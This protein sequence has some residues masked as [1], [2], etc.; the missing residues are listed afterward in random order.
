MIDIPFTANLFMN[1]ENLLQIYASGFRKNWELP[2]LTEFGSDQTMTYADLARRIAALHLLYE[3]AGIKRGDKIAVMGKNSFAW[4]VVYMATLTYGAVIVPVLHDFNVQDAQHIINHSESVMLFINESIFDSMEFEKIPAVKAVL[5][6]D[7]RAVLAEHPVTNRVVE[8]FLA[9]LPQ[10][11]R[12]RYPHGFTTADVDYPEIDES[13]LAEINYTSGTTGFSKGVMLTLGNLGGNVRFGMASRLHYRGSRALSFLPLAHAYGCAFDMLTPLAV[14]T[15]ITILGKLPTP[16]LLLK[17]FAEVRPNLIIC[18][19]LILEKIYRNKLRPIIEKP[20][21]R[22]ALKLPGL[23]TLVYRKI[24]NSLVEA[25][26]GEFE[27]VIVGGAPLNHE[28]EA[29]LHKIKFPFTVGYGMTECGPLISYTP[30]RNFIVSS[31]GRTLPTMES[32]IAG[33]RNPE[34]EPG[35]ICVR[36]ENVM[37][38]YFK[39]PEATEAVIDAEGWLHTG[40]M[41]T[42]SDRGTIFIRG[43]YKTMI[44]G[45]SGQNIYPEEIEAKLNNMPYVS[46]SLVVERGKHLV[47]LVYPDYE[48]MDRDKVHNEQLPALME[49]VRTDL[50]RIVAPY[51]R[52]DR[53][54]LIANEFEKTPKRSIKRY[55]YN[56]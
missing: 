11:M 18:V 21:V 24:R 7:R 46:E 15:H 8:K 27:E 13:T 29:F 1:K 26:G 52:I 14:G 23:K 36:G 49:Q 47:A 20:S 16:K 35:E 39:N 33:S 5:S 45:A 28:V 4:V 9:R 17:A 42:I 43:R 44:L 51:E 55:L 22:R 25:L 40:D 38:G 32:K 41:G 54:Q 37:K 3:E 30:W 53:I 56:A 6:L 31:S 34:T 48:A 12:R 10:K 50:N 2:A 19:P